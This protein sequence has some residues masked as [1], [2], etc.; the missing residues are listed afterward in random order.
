MGKSAIDNDICDVGREGHWSN[1]AMKSG[2]GLC[3]SEIDFL[4]SGRLFDNFID[5]IEGP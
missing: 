1:C 5:L 4:A 3:R 2:A